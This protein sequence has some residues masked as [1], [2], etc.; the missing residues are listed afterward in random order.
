[1]VCDGIRT[2]TVVCDHIK[3]HKQTMKKNNNNNDV[4]WDAIPWMRNKEL[5]MSVLSNLLNDAD[6]WELAG[7][8]RVSEDLFSDPLNAIIYRV[9]SGVRSNNAPV[10][11]ISVFEALKGQQSN[12]VMIRFGDLMVLAQDQAHFPHHIYALRELATRRAI[13]RVCADLQAKAQ[14]YAFPVEEALEAMNSEV[15]RLTDTVGTRTYETL[16]EVIRK[17]IDEIARV[18]SGEEPMGLLL[19]YPSLDRL[20]QGLQTQEMV[21]LAARPSVG[22]SLFA[23][24][25]GLNVALAGGKVAYF[26]LEMSNRELGKRSISNLTGVDG[27]SLRDESDLGDMWKII[28]ALRERI[29]LD[30]FFLEETPALSVA[31]F[32][33]KARVL[34]KKEGVRLIIIDYLQLMT[35]TPR[36]A[37]R[38]NEVAAISRAIKATAKALKI[39]IIAL[40]Q[41]SRD[42]V[43]RTGGLGKPQLSDLRESGAI[44]QDADTVI[45]IHRPDFTGMSDNPEERNRATIILAKHR[46][47]ILGEVDFIADTNRMRF[48]EKQE[49]LPPTI[50]YSSF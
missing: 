27:S 30:R 45:F 40:S 37:V 31:E 14:D 24:N 8:L 39:P 12:E 17:S 43:K 19:G 29:D 48:V 2:H 18:K 38:E 20:L 1:M 36:M 26:T 10:D 21:V 15:E 3:I 33:S 35:V 22:K 4:S 34:V 46:N 5:E 7:E 13:Y 25:I 23:L 9:M 42:V 28:E 49:D 11:S 47:G 41:L 50:E 44:E 16:L 32:T 6:C